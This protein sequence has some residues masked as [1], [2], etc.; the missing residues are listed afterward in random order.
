[1]NITE[2]QVQ[3]CIR[4]QLLLSILIYTLFGKSEMRVTLRSNM[5]CT[6]DSGSSVSF[7]GAILTSAH[8]ILPIFF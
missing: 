5:A 2:L 3:Y 7:K 4:T 1:M 8:I 6:S